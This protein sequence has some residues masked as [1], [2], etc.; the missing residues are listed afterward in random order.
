[1]RTPKKPA[2]TWTEKEC[3]ECLVE[4]EAVLGIF[5]EACNKKGK[6]R[7]KNVKVKGLGGEEEGMRSAGDV[8]RWGVGR[9]WVR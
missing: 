4:V 3:Y 6:K 8:R 5:V 7:S 9:G 1:M 2:T